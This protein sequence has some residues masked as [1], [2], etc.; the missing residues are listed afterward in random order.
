MAK[1]KGLGKGRGKGYKNI[2]GKDPMVHSQSAKGRKQPQRVVTKRLTP[3]NLSTRQIKRKKEADERFEQI[4]T[5][6]G[7][8]IRDKKTG[9]K[10]TFWSL[11]S[12]NQLNLVKG[13]YIDEK[14]WFSPDEHEKEFHF[15]Q[16]ELSERLHRQERLRR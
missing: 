2:I 3:H 8:T 11:E 14:L 1:R 16:S 5:T 13:A 9:D 7:F 10:I 4:Y 6:D 12:E 15:S